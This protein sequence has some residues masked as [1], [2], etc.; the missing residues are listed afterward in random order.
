MP[1]EASD[2]SVWVLI[3]A[4]RGDNNQLLALA[5]ALGLP[6]ETRQLRTNRLHWLPLRLLGATFATL[7]PESRAAVSGEAPDLVLAIGRRS[8]PVV[9]AIRQGSRERTRLVHLGNPRVPVR[10]FDLVVTT[11]Q[12]PVADAPN[13][14]KFPIGIGRPS[15]AQDTSAASEEAK[16]F[17]AAMPH[18][19]RLL[20]LGG[21]TLFWKL[22]PEDVAR[23]AKAL[24]SQVEREGGSLI[25]L[26][27][28]RT[29]KAALVAARHAIENS[30]APAAIAAMEGPPSYTTLLEAADSLFVTA[31]SVSMVTEALRTGKPVG[32]VPVRRTWAGALWLA[33]SDLL[34]PGRPAFPRD[35]R[36]FWA[37]LERDGLAGSVERPRSGPIPDVPEIAA[38]RVRQ[39]LRLPP[40]P[41]TGGRDSD[42]STQANPA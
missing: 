12:Y 9:R 21:P 35:L 26:P 37:A 28:P 32:L 40:R 29:P 13:V 30:R 41:A 6:F 33:L 15:Q 11:P 7:K 24:L 38:G 19:R 18:P 23:A 4:R 5:E 14:L 34:R 31:D 8:V 25:V 27:S 3:G 17:L 42:R 36:C 39:L 22:D 10:H 20:L 16:R 1:A 2:P